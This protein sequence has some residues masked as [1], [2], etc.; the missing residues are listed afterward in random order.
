MSAKP[1]LG[2]PNPKSGPLFGDF[3]QVNELSH[4]YKA[5]Q[6]VEDREKVIE[7][8]CFWQKHLYTK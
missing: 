2:W 4:S 8:M 5:T 6:P 1:D 3:Y 7:R